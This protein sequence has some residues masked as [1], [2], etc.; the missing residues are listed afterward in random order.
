M[1]S[2]SV[3]DAAVIRAEFWLR[4]SQFMSEPENPVPRKAALV[5]PGAFF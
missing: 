1:R 4:Y 5:E 3:V 2:K